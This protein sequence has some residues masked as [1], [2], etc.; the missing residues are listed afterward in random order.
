MSSRA[1]IL[2]TWNE[3]DNEEIVQYLLQYVFVCLFV[4]F[5]LFAIS[6]A[7]LVTYGGS[8]VRGQI[9]AAAAG[10]CQSHCHTG[11]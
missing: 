1:G 2:P 8:Q 6:W 3:R 5:C 11:I 9:G 4:C 7:A 10:L